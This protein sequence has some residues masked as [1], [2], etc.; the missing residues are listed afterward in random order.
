MQRR[1]YLFKRE[2]NEI[3]GEYKHYFLSPIYVS[4]FNNLRQSEFLISS[5]KQTNFFFYLRKFEIQFQ[6]LLTIKYF[7]V[8][9]VT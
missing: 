5:S 3:K 1:E 9:F 8:G 7:V 2:N 4:F 6:Y